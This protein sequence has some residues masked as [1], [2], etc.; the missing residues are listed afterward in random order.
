M[1]LATGEK[2]LTNFTRRS[3][4]DVTGVLDTPRKLT[5]I[6]SLKMKKNYNCKIM[7]ATKKPSEINFRGQ[8]P[9][10]RHYSRAN[11]VRSNF[12]GGNF[13]GCGGFFHGHIFPDTSNA[14]SDFYLMT[15]SNRTLRRSSVN[16]TVYLDH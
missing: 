8:F 9:W 1:T 12:L 15:F 14:L 16:L 6:K 7:S 10:G 13:P 5:N 2:L 11:F 3:I 4:I